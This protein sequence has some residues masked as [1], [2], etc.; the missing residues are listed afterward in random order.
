MKE[1]L[2]KTTTLALATD[3]QVQQ[4]ASQHN[5]IVH[6]RGAAIELMSKKFQEHKAAKAAQ[7]DQAPAAAKRARDAQGDAKESRPARWCDVLWTMILD[8]VKEAAKSAEQAN[9]Q[10]YACKAAPALFQLD[11]AKTVESSHF[12]TEEPV[13]EEEEENGKVW[14]TTVPFKLGD[15]GGVAQ[16][17]LFYDLQPF[18]CRDT[19]SFHRDRPSDAGR[20]LAREIKGRGGGCGRGTRRKAATAAA[21]SQAGA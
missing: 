6:I 12:H 16:D 3:K 8:H 2:R 10:A 20:K 1:A 9:A 14:R 19:I 13:E 18:S 15:A 5:L 4:L 11:P 7:E 17:L 21:A